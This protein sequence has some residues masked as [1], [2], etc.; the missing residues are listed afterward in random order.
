VRGRTEQMNVS[1]T[2]QLAGF[3]RESVSSGMY[4]NASELMREALRRMK[5]EGER[6]RL[7]VVEDPEETGRRIK[8]A[9]AEVERGE[10]TDYDAAGL[11]AFGERVI[12]ELRKAQPT[13][14]KKSR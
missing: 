9:I 6:G 5:S 1:L 11:T 2:P 4:N 8:S 10:F 7:N 3:V 14:R 13:S 12:S